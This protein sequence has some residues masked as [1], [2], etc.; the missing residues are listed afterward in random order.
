[1][2]YQLR[3]AEKPVV[4]TVHE[5]WP[6]LNGTIRRA[7]VRLLF[8]RM[9]RACIRR[10]STVVTTQEWSAHEL[11][12]LA[13]GHRIQTI[14]VGSSI[15]RAGTPTS[16]RPAGF[17][18]VLFG[19][20]AAMHSPTIEALGAWLSW[21]PSEV[22]LTWLGRSTDEMRRAGDSLGLPANRV[23]YLGRLPAAEVSAV[24]ESSRIGLAPYAD[25]ASTRRTTFVALLE[26]RLP[27]VALDGITTS[28]WMRESG[29]CVWVPEGEPARFKDALSELLNDLPRQSALSAR[30]GDVFDERLAWPRIGEAYAR[31]LSE[32]VS[33]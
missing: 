21:A 32:G 10:S 18:L 12:S 9:L 14:P 15:P 2:A 1:M 3:A 19:Q 26:H 4:L 31:L 5:Y 23:T 6:P 8:R 17:R 27:I 24:L 29:A 22:S 25:G 13:R 30:A 33:A 16:A 11:A 20:P 7:V 28:D